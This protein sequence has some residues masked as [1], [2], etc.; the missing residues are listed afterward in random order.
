L[1]GGQLKEL[2]ALVEAHQGRLALSYSH[3]RGPLHAVLTVEMAAFARQHLFRQAFVIVAASA[4]HKGLLLFGFGHAL[5]VGVPQPLP[6][7]RHFRL[8]SGKLH[9]L[10]EVN[11]D[12]RW[13]AAL[14][15]GPLC[16]AQVLAVAL[17]ALHGFESFVAE[18]VEASMLLVDVCYSLRREGFELLLQV[19]QRKTLVSV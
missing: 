8:N 10:Q 11:V 16:F 19:T 4:L 2:V 12:I 15:I 3:L 9:F 7:L 6:M 14:M 17:L 5:L 1:Q 18:V 13:D